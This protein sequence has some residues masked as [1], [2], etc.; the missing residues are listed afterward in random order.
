VKSQQ[1]EH[2]WLVVWNIWI[3]FSYSGDDDPIWRSYF[4]GGV[5]TT[6]Q[7]EL[8]EIYRHKGQASCQLLSLVTPSQSFWR[9]SGW[10]DVFTGVLPKT[11]SRRFL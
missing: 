5:E 2:G 9:S 10:R 11:T 1:D 8:N 7:M 3:I 4:S 6:N